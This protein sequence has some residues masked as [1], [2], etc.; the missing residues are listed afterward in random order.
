MHVH[1]GLNSMHTIY[2][3]L[4]TYLDMQFKED[5]VKYQY[6]PSSMTFSHYLKNTLVGLKDKLSSILKLVYSALYEDLGKT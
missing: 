2:F 3:V 6:A 5:E 4:K 1:T